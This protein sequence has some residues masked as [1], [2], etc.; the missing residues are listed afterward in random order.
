MSDDSKTLLKDL[1]QII[2]KEKD[3]SDYQLSMEICNLKSKY[4]NLTIVSYK[5]KNIIDE[6]VTL[7]CKNNNISKEDYFGVLPYE[8]NNKKI[9]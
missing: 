7:F 1:H 3:M 6:R 4:P 8:K 2:K 9:P 5:L